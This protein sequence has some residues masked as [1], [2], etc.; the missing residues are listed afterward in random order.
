MAGEYASA[1]YHGTVR[2]RR[3]SPQPHEFSYNVFMMYLDTA[4]LDSILSLSPFWSDKPWAIAR[5]KR[6]DFHIDQESKT[7]IGQLPS[8]AESIRITVA[9]ATGLK[10]TGP[11]RMLVNLRYW[12]YSINPI[13]TYYCFDESGQNVIAIVAEVK[14]TPWKE[15]HAYVL[16]GDDFSH[17]Q[18]CTFAKTFHVSPFNPIDMQYQWQSTAPDKTLAI[19]LENWQRGE[20][21]MDATMTLRRTPINSKSLNRILIH[22]PFMTVKVVIAIYWQ[23]LKLFAKRVPVFNHPNNHLN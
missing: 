16:T 14:N 19:H 3:F 15:R 6:A 7:A 5:F 17:K 10:P 20:L 1:I 18:Q 9:Q 21:V 11:I 4:E 23:A 2:H 12:G 22:F 8:V 13:S